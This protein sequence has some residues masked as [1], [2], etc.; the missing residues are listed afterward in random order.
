LEISH[1]PR[2][3]FI[4]RDLNMNDQRYDESHLRLMKL[5]DSMQRDSKTNTR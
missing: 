3:N 4:R 1:E 5:F 2:R